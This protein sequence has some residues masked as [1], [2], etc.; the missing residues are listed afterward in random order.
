ME[1]KHVA[2]SMTIQGALIL[3]LT[4]ALTWIG[5][6]PDNSN[7]AKAVEGVLILAGFGMTVYGRM[8]AKKDLFIK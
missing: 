6:E 4:G 2:R 1:K 5:V 8:R 7:V 3:F